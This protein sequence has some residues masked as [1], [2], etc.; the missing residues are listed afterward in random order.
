M[1]TGVPRRHSSCVLD[2]PHSSGLNHSLDTFRLLVKKKS[3]FVQFY[4]VNVVSVFMFGA[5]IS[6]LRII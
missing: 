2:T 5:F 4:Y 1:I 6:I 3:H